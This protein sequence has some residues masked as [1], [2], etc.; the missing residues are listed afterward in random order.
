MKTSFEGP[1]ELRRMD[2]EF[3]ALDPKQSFAGGGA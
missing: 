3:P 1:K 2:A